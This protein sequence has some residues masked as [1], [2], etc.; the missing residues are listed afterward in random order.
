MKDG[1]FPESLAP[2]DGA[3]ITGSPAS[4]HDDGAWIPRLE[5]LVRDMARSGLPLFGACFGHQIIAKALGGAVE[6][7]PDGWVFGAIRTRLLA[8]KQD[9]AAYA[10][11]SEQVTRLPDGPRPSQRRQTGVRLPATPSER[12]C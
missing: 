10:A 11:H 2:F 3:I 5:A 7:N 6:A 12:P 1:V 8:D 4:V 9:V